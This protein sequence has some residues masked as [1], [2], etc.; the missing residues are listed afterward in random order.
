VPGY[1]WRPFTDV[2]DAPHGLCQRSSEIST[3]L[4]AEAC[5]PFMFGSWCSHVNLTSAVGCTRGQRCLE[6]NATI[7]SVHTACKHPTQLLTHV[8]SH[9]HTT[10]VT[11]LHA[12]LESSILRTCLRKIDAAQPL[13]FLFVGD[14][15]TGMLLSTLV[16]WAERGVNPP[17]RRLHYGV[18]DSTGG[19]GSEGT[20]PLL[21]RHGWG[22]RAA[23]VRLNAMY[24]SNGLKKDYPLPLLLQNI[25]R[26]LTA[27]VAPHAG[28]A[29]DDLRR[30][31]L[32]IFLGQGTWCASMTPTRHCACVTPT[33]SC[34]LRMH[35]ELDVGVWPVL[36]STYM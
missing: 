34:T 2:C 3:D 9:N 26:S 14:S 15:Q 22:F 21:T 32:V 27:L 18:A 36:T 24:G 20:A 4:C 10:L 8:D 29:G 30:V 35:A 23:W 16:R 7:E 13:R 28:K 31:R 33:R 11:P 25:N 19:A 17:D 6:L 5:A 12:H 1:D